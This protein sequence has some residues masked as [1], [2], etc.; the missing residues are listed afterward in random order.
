MQKEDSRTIIYV[1]HGEDT[2][3]KHRYDEKLTREGKEGARELARQ[4]IDKYG[5]PDAIYCSP[6][7]RT[8]QTRRQMLKVVDEYTDKKIK[9]VTDPRLSRY[10]TRSQ[11]RNPDIRGD[12]RKKK[13]PIYESWDDFKR[14]VKKQ[15]RDMENKDK[16]DV[17]WCIGHTLIIK[18]VA[19]YKGIDRPDHIKYLDTVIIEIDKE[20]NKEINKESHK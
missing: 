7:Y 3:S 16:Y 20:I 4:L 9:N 2:R 8:R 11:E 15:L 5:I 12:T 6:F 17:I 10:F 19:R 14:R 18:H 13:A 1:R